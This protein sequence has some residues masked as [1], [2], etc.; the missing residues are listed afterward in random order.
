MNET[1]KLIRN[2]IRC[3]DGTVIESRHRHDFQPHKQE[4]GREYSVDGGLC[5]QH[6]S[7]SDLEFENLALYEGDPHEKIR[8]GFSWC[9]VLDENSNR[10]PQPV[11]TLLKDLTD[12]HLDNLIEF[13]KE[14]YPKHIHNVFLAEKEWR[15]DN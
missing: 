6:I 11:F 14:D 8:G 15:S 5:Y 10:R 4:D 1:Q 2:A 7:F 3:P 13:T 9:S 12:D